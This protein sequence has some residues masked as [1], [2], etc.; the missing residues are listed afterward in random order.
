MKETDVQGVLSVAFCSDVHLLQ[1]PA[2][3]A[4]D[5]SQSHDDTLSYLQTQTRVTVYWGPAVL[6]ISGEEGVAGDT[7]MIS[8]ESFLKQILVQRQQ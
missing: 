3:I 8:L 6:I 1:H 2:S 4:L 5:P 7:F